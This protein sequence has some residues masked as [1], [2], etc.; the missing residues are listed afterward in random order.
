MNYN[1]YTND[2]IR[3]TNEGILVI[4]RSGTI[5]FHN[6]AARDLLDFEFTDQKKYAALM[7]SN[8]SPENDEF[9]QS[10]LQSIYDKETIHHSSTRYVRKNG[11]VIY[12]RTTSNYHP[13]HDYLVFSFIDVTEN[14][15]RRIQQHDASLIS[16]FTI[17]FICIWVYLVMLWRS[18]GWDSSISSDVMTLV[19]LTLGGIVCFICVRFTSLDTKHMGL[20]VPSKK[21][22]RTDLTISGIILVVFLIIKL[23]L[24]HVNPGYFATSAFCNWKL[25]LDASILFYPVNVFIQ[26]FLTRGCFQEALL[27][28]FVG[29]HKD[30][31]VIVISSLMFG[32]LHLHK[33][34]SYML[35]TPVFLFFCSILYQKQ[36]NVWGLCIIHYVCLIGAK[37]LG[38]L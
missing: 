29:K 37:V 19:Q 17:A 12:L 35:V 20:S 4:D 23:I 15:T 10:I 26:E 3:N 9:H 1:D 11:D 28:T 34:F 2:I 18:H 13:D 16:A 14:E 21:I 8:P 27:L 36:R 30:L 5:L 25:F 32:A 7:S 6:N 24:L 22:L 31:L 38:L 33:P